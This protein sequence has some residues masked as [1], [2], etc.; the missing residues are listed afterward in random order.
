MPVSFNILLCI[1]RT[2]V[3]NRGLYFLAMITCSQHS[4]AKILMAFLS[5]RITLNK[6]NSG[7]TASAVCL[8]TLILMKLDQEGKFAGA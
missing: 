5:K 2:L 8:L 7:V 4:C 3:I 6:S 1:T